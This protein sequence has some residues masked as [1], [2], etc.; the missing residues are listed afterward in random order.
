MKRWLLNPAISS[1]PQGGS[2]ELECS[3]K[4]DPVLGTGHPD[5]HAAPRPHP[6]FW[7]PRA[8][9][10]GVGRAGGGRRT[11]GPARGRRGIRPRWMPWPL[12]NRKTHSDSAGRLPEHRW[13]RQTPPPPTTTD[14][15]GRRGP[16]RA[17]RSIC[18][19]YESSTSSWRCSAA[20]GDRGG[21]EG[22]GRGS[23]GVG[24]RRNVGI[25]S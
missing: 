12:I 9:R 18:W 22:G 19:R 17:V 15:G 7:E 4:P 23:V 1:S 20:S 24:G 25:H 11:W 6:L 5:K 16:G 21:C 3:R 10:G 14:P 13:I 2:K 8:A